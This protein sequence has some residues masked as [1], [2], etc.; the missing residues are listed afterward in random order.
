MQVNT[1]MSRGAGFIAF[2]AGFD[3]LKGNLRGV[4]VWIHL[5]IDDLA[6]IYVK[7]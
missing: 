5:E 7:Q 2:V 1:C 4:Q 3:V 6:T